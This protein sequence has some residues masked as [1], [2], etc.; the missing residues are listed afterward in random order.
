MGPLSG[1]TYWINS[2]TFSSDGARIAS[3]SDDGT[4]RVWD[5]MSGRL[6]L[7]PLTG[8][9][10]L[11]DFV[12]FSSDS[13]RIISLTR[14]GTV[15][16]WNA[17]TG[18]LVAGPLLRHAEGALAV[19]F[20]P[21]SSWSAVSPDGRWIAAL[22]GDLSGIFHVWDSKTGQVVASLKKHTSNFMSITFSLDSR[23]VLTS[24]LDNTICVHTLD[25]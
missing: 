12:A 22:D 17:D 20:T 19:V 4:V 23:R 9:R 13:K 24:S 8:H 2:V 3:T 10:D 11:K 16:V 18:V 21:T 7:G 15:R 14:L 5:A 25:S 6:V 1:H